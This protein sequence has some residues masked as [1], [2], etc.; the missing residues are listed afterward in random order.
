MDGFDGDGLTVDYILG[1]WNVE[2]LVCGAVN[3]ECTA[4][5]FCCVVIGFVVTIASFAKCNGVWK[6]CWF[7]IVVPSNF[8]C[9]NMNAM[10]KLAF[11]NLVWNIV[12]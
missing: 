2:W 4:E 12:L 3:K 10:V 1:C 6:A 9:G 5:I 7:C 11:P 8:F